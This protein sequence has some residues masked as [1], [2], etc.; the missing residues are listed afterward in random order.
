MLLSLSNLSIIASDGSGD[1]KPIVRWIHGLNAPCA[2]Q[3]LSR[4][5]PGFDEKCI[6]TSLGSLEAFEAQIEKGCKALEAESEYLSQGFTLLGFSQGGLIA[7]AILQGCS[8]GK[9]VRRL[10]TVGGPHMGVAI[11]PNSS[12]DSYANS[13]FIKMCLFSLFKNHIGP[14]GYIR[15]LKYY[16]SYVASHNTILD[17]NN[18]IN[19]NQSYKDRILGLELF[20][21]IGFDNDHMIQPKNTAVFGF[22]KDQDYSS[23]VGLEDTFVFQ[24]NTIGIKDLSESGRLYRCIVPGEHLRITDDEM[25]KLVSDFSNIH[26]TDYK[27]NYDYMKDKCIFKQ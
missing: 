12:P 8:V 16:D 6:D 14:C 2:I 13:I 24:K 20:M 9:Y 5:F 1:V 21:A 3:N 4:F 18:E 22:Y 17:L 25:F 15:S 26:N 23:Y 10:I 19:M 7:R 27:K 11:V